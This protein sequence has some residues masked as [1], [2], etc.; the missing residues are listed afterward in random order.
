MLANVS[1]T[2]PTSNHIASMSCVYYQGIITFTCYTKLTTFMYA[3]VGID[4]ASSLS[5]ATVQVV[6]N[7]NT[8][9]TF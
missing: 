5:V 3:F 1:N 6:W 7:I 2:G 8:F 9:T 4:I